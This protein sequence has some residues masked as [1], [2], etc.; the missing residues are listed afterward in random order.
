MQRFMSGLEP[1]TYCTLCTVNKL[2]KCTR[3]RDWFFYA[4]DS[5][6][7]EH[8]AHPSIVLATVGSF[9]R[10]ACHSPYTLPHPSIVL[11][12]VGSFR[13]QAW[14]SILYHTLRQL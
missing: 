3:T 2:Y 5:E 1:D 8:S 12:T 4:G 7:F 6:Y 9:R 11:A 14:H 13:I 10:Q